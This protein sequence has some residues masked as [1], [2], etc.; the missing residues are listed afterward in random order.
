MR[1]LT[2]Y[3]GHYDGL[4]EPRPYWGYTKEYPSITSISNDVMSELPGNIFKTLIVALTYPSIGIHSQGPVNVLHVKVSAYKT[5]G[6]SGNFRF[7]DIKPTI[8]ELISQLDGNGIKFYRYEYSYLYGKS[9]WN[10]NLSNIGSITKR[11]VE[12]F[13]IEFKL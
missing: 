2:T 4:L 3:E 12:S 1:Y 8:I 6:R 11:G 5:H 13:T 10:R 9:D 7:D